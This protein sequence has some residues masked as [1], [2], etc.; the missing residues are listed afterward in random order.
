MRY[1]RLA[2]VIAF[3]LFAVKITQFF[4]HLVRT[5]RAW[6]SSL[7]DARRDLRGRGFDRRGR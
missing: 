3:I 4:A 7:L 2:G 1:L 5:G 6:D